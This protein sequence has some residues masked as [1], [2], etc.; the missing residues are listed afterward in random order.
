MDTIKAKRKH[1]EVEAMLA[2]YCPHYREKKRNCKYK[3]IAN[4][5]VQPIPIEFKAIDENG[6]V[7]YVV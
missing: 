2:E 3:T 5:E 7:L 4:L 1:D 6:D